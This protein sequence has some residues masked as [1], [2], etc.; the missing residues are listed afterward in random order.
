[1]I[2]AYLESQFPLR[3]QL[4]LYISHKSH[5]QIH[6]LFRGLCGPLEAPSRTLLDV[7]EFQVKNLCSRPCNSIPCSRWALP[8]LSVK[9]W[10]KKEAG[11]HIIRNHISSFPHQYF[12]WE[13]LK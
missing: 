6:A 2:L 9:I 10:K 8:E 7:L 4:K 5:G 13:A 3:F 11:G 12:L 1:M